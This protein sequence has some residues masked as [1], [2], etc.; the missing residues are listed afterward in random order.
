METSLLNHF[1]M[2]SWG[3]SAVALFYQVGEAPN[4]REALIRFRALTEGLQARKKE[5]PQS[6]FNSPEAKCV[7]QL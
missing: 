2:Q 1:F 3:V 4:C 7:V 5:N 6:I